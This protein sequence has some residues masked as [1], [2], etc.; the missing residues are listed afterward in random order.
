MKTIYDLKPSFQNFLR[1]IV[2]YLAHRG[3]TPNHITYAAVL[4][5]CIAGGAISL[6]Q[7]A[8]WILLTIPLV[9]F[10]R[11]ALNAMD[12]ML[13]KEHAMKTD[14]GAMLNEMGDVLSDTALYLPFALISGISVFWVVLFV[15]VAI[16]TEMAGVLGAVIGGV[17]RYDGPMGK[18]DR[19][20][21]MGTLS[22]VLGLGVSPNGWFDGVMII[23]TLMSVWTVYQRATKGIKS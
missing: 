6:S 19:A 22:L 9:M 23:I 15:I 21:V 12:G 8:S 3:I 10:V 14:G 18:S 4:L 11:M 5:S 7:G 13:A 20:F 1:P 16:F 2:Q 17:R